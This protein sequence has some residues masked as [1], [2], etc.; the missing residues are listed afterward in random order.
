[1]KKKATPK[2][3]AANEVDPRFAPVVRALSRERDVT[4]G[5]KGFGSS[6]LKVKG[7]LFAMM[8][9]KGNFVAKLP[10]TRVTELVQQGKGE[11]FDPGHGRLMT[12]WVSLAG[13]PASWVDLAKEALRFV[14]G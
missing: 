3:K 6:G 14:G 12:E 4:Y 10:K 5:G 1:V 2:P 13:S 7:K 9:S 8:S 11:Y